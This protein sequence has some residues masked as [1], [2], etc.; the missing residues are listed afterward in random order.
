ME[1]LRERGVSKAKR[2]NG[3]YE[4]KLEIP[5]GGG[6]K[7]KNLLWRSMDVFWNHTL[8]EINISHSLNELCSFQI[9]NYITSDESNAPLLLIGNAG[10]GKSAI[11]A[12]SANEALVKAERGELPGAK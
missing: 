7:P 3:K 12:K 9:Q 11:M 2:F 1:I 4:A 8:V 6:F 5:G 10:S